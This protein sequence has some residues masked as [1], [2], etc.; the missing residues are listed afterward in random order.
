MDGAL[1]MV[2]EPHNS[3]TTAYNLLHCWI[4]EPNEFGGLPPS[5]NT[6]Y[7]SAKY[8]QNFIPQKCLPTTFIS[9]ICFQS[10]LVID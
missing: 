7:D 10:V 4:M 3:Y 8:K 9:C 1:K 2:I 5:F 6:S